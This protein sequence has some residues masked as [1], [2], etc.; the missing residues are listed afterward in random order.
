MSNFGETANFLWSVADLIRDSFKRGKYQ[1]VILPY[2]VLRRLD[3][4]LEPT[5]EAVLKAHTEYKHKIDNLDPLLRKTSGLAFYNTSRFN[6]R[7]LL[8]DAPNL[9]A[10]LRVYLNSFSPNIREVFEKFDFDNTI[11]KLVEA[12]LLFKVMERFTHVDLSPERVD[13]HAMGSIYEELLRR[14]NEALNENPGEH[15]T[16]REIIRLMVRLMVEPDRER[17]SGSGVTRTVYDPC[18][19]SGGMLSITKEV[20]CGTSKGFG[21]S[22]EPLTGINAN[23]QIFLFGQEVNPETYA[24]SKADFYISDPTGTDADNITFGSVLSNDRF[25]GTK[26]DYLIA[27]PPYGKDWKR[28]E[29]EVKAENQRGFAGRFGAG[30]PSI[31]DGQ[32][33]FLE[34]MVNHFRLA[35]D[36]GSR[37][38]IVMNGS[39]LFTGDAS[40][41]PSEIRRWI[42]ENDLLDVLIGLPEQIFYNTGIATYVWILSNRKPA[43]RKGKVLLIDA[44][45]FWKPMRKS[46]GNKRRELGDEHIQ[47]IVDLYQD[48]EADDHCKLFDTTD[49]GYRKITVERPLQLNFQVTPKR[50][51][52]LKAERSFEN[53]AK[54]RKKKPAEKEAE[55]EAGRRLQEEIVAMLEGHMPTTLFKERPSFEGALKKAAKGSGL[56]LSTSIKKVILKGLSEHDETAEVCRDSKGNPEADSDLRDYENVPLGEDIKAYFERE[57][58]PHVPDAWINES[59]TD[60]RDGGIGKIGYE[61]NFNRF[62]YVYEPPR[63]LGEIEG[64]IRT[65]E[66]EIIE[67]LQE[68]TA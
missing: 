37:M 42:L 20:I 44:S 55:E 62:F 39:P 45:G 59:V 29:D 58:T 38:A 51:E 28:D 26:F 15:F 17:L 36:G 57:V 24:V 16:P 6:F 5:K 22:D 14:F 30:L 47:Q 53:L 23:A 3:L 60:D 4:V 2:T 8:D 65:L 1:D 32:M 12:G 50:I 54:S 49:F 35:E 43:E 67:M 41:G 33:L 68:V 52:R 13:N 66:K 64:D 46:L 63:P 7:R 21:T 48:Y 56:T 19:G 27:N 34:H 31:S 40:S 10:N 9:A 18:C 25:S 11:T 61:I